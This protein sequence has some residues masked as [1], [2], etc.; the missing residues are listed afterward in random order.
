MLIMEDMWMVRA[1]KGG[2][3]FKDF[4]EL[5]LVA[6]EWKLGNLSGKSPDEIKQIMKK[7][8]N[9]ENIQTI[10]FFSGQTKKF[11]CEFEIDDFVITFNPENSKYLVGKITSDYYYSDKLAKLH[12]YDGYYCQCRDVEWIGE[13]N[14][15][16]LKSTT[17]HHLKYSAAVFDLD[18]SVKSDFLKKINHEE[19]V[20]DGIGD[21]GIETV[22]YWLISAGY[23]SIWWNQ[24]LKDNVVGI[25]MSGTGDLRQYDSKKEIKVKFQK[26]F[27]DKSSHMN[28]VHACWQFV[29]EMQIGDIIFVKNGTSEIIGRGVIESDYEYDTKRPFHNI[30]KVTWTHKGKWKYKKGNLITKTLTEITN[31]SD[32]VKKLIDLVDDGGIVKP[33]YP[34]YTKQKLDNGRKRY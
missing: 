33:V 15:E 4:K 23:G 16:D 3:L 2:S 18:D 17:N 20:D 32:L 30:R 10:G 34:N 25:G 24:F 31:Y 8:Y 28:D 21:G 19:E 29:H 26:H 1:G 11:V 5:K 12:G 6:I 9:K 14:K 13:V 27:H 7:Q 22:R